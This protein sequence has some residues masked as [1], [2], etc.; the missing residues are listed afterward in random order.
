MLTYTNLES[1]SISHQVLKRSK[2][3][4]RDDAQEDA[5]DVQHHTCPEQTM[6]MY[7]IPAAFHASKLIVVLMVA[8]PGVAHFCIYQM[9]LFKVAYIS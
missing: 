4:S 7:H 2:E 1:Y 9:L 8:R 6:Q 3:S 5:D